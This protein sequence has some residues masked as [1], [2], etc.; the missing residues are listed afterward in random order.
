MQGRLSLYLGMWERRLNWWESHNFKL[1]D[2]CSSQEK[3]SCEIIYFCFFVCASRITTWHCEIS[4]SIW[5]PLCSL[6][7]NLRSEPSLC[8]LPDANYKPSS[9]PCKS[10]I[11]LLPWAAIESLVM[12]ATG[13]GGRGKSREV[14]AVQALLVV[15]PTICFTSLDHAS[16]G[17]PENGNYTSSYARRNST[18][19]TSCVLTDIVLLCLLGLS[20]TYELWGS[21]PNLRLH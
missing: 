4:T 11:N 17:W 2:A 15:E 19:G 6:R 20:I 21:K 16:H 5:K 13:L 14:H 9:L 3:E 18:Y 12:W 1:E 7:S 10:Q 8:P